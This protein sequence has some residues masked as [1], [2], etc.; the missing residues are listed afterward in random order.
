M[1]PMPVVALLQDVLGHL[2]KVPM[3]VVVLLE[4]VLGH[5]V[6]VP[7]LVVALL[8]D[9]PGP[10]VKVPMNVLKHKIEYMDKLVSTEVCFCFQTTF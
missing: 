5:L 9:V 3:P 4:D 6:K 10:L 8:R 7:M 2:A 1:V